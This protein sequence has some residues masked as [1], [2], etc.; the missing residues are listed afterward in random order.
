[1]ATFVLRELRLRQ[2]RNFD[3]LE[4]HFPPEGVAII[5]ENGSGK[6]NL[7]EAIGYLE[8]FRSFRGA[9]DEQLVRFGA[10][11][12]HLRGRLGDASRVHREI[13]A[14][15]EVSRGRRKRVTVDGAEPERI[16][17]AIGLLG[18]VIFSPS[19]VAIIRGSPAERRR[20]LDIIL[21]LNQPGYLGALQRYR[22]VL[23]QRNAALRDTRTY[24][25]DAWNVALIET[26]S[27]LLAD[28]MRW[29]ME[30]TSG[31]ETHYATISGGVQGTISYRPGLGRGTVEAPD[32]RAI[33]AVFSN[34]L[35]RVAQR[36]RDRGVTLVGP[37][38]DE[39]MFEMNAGNNTVDL[40]NYGS[41]GQVRTAAIALRLVEAE[42][43]RAQR[44]VDPVILLDDVFAEL[45]RPRSERIF[46][47]IHEQR[48]GQVILTAPKESDLVNR[49]AALPRWR[50][51]V[52]RIE[53]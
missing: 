23:R 13:S 21:S 49:H 36:E 10:D 17:E 40:R 53:S 4:L 34:E 28:R 12:F 9:P 24:P 15:F 33:A 35:Q 43:A 6:T 50:I 2:Y 20:F 19:D 39:L 46:E 27:R 7:L 1:M 14:A 11:A 44:G 32:E 25:L 52:G 37:H 18:A 3:E 42:T 16:G 48:P 29:V 22:H 5:G 41:G 26:G 30:R 47:L 31:F 38:R 51:A 8:I 45:D